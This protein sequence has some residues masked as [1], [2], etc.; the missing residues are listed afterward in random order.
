LEESWEELGN[1][2][3]RVLLFLLFLVKFIRQE[4]GVSSSEF[5]SPCPWHRKAGI[6]GYKV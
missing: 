5:L 6:S 2:G 3:R 4:W 1:V